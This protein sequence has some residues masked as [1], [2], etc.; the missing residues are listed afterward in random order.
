MPALNHLL[1]GGL[2]R[3]RGIAGDAV[4]AAIVAAAR[5]PRPGTAIWH[6]REIARAAT[7][8]APV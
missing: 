7:T 3:Y 2:D 1:V 4:G 8:G 5:T 6:N